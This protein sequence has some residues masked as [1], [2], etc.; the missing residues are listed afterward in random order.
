M[1]DTIG[2]TQSGSN[3][4]NWDQLIESVLSDRHI[5][6]FA[7]IP[8]DNLK[9]ISDPMNRKFIVQSVLRSLEQTNNPQATEANANTVTDLMTKLASEFLGKQG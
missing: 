8:E 1:A 5:D 4:V 9:F 7:S 2:S 3:G 6:V